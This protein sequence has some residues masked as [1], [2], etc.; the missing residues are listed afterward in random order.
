MVG[1]RYP[2]TSS[3]QLSSTNKFQLCFT[4]NNIRLDFG[5]PRNGSN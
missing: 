3:N 2:N 4:Q 5:V 1:H